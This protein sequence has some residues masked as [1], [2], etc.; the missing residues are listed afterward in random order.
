M[1]I[2]TKSGDGGAFPLA[3]QSPGICVA[4]R[5]KCDNLRVT[6]GFPRN[7]QWEN[8]PFQQL[9]GMIAI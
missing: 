3:S 8:L 6:Y 5:G 1:K 2:Y 9:G 4:S 7:L